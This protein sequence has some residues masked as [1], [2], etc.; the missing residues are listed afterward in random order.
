MKNSVRCRAARLVRS[1]RNRV[2]YYYAQFYVDVTTIVATIHRFQLISHR[3]WWITFG[4]THDLFLSI[5]LLASIRWSAAYY[6]RIV[7]LY[8]I[9]RAC[10]WY[11][12][13]V[14]VFF[15]FSSSSS[16]FF[17]LIITTIVDGGVCMPK[18]RYASLNKIIWI[19]A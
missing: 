8:L 19:K 5:Y 12:A 13:C 2:N 6:S 18:I 14:V 15:P 7:W 9:Q 16:S 11:V 3:N 17:S 4:I 1:S 10:I